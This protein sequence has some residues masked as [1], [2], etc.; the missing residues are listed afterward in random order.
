MVLAVEAVER[1]VNNGGFS[2]LFLNSSRRWIA[3]FV[4]ALRAVGREDVANLAQEAI[5]LLRVVGPPTAQSV[6]DAVT[7]DDDRRDEALDALDSR[8]YEEAG[9]LSQTFSLLSSRM[10][11]RSCSTVARVTFGDPD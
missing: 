3:D 10:L 9:D 8:Y 5:D 7:T 2:E 4:P 1:E 6:R 11:M